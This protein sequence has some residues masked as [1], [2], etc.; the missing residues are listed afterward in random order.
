MRDVPG[1]EFDGCTVQQ[2]PSGGAEVIA[3][4]RRDEQFGPVIVVGWG[5]LLVELMRDVQMAPAPITRT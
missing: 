5:G 1:A 2:M 4:A 3:G